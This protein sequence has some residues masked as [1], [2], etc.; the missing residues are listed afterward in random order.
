M[1]A[2]TSGPIVVNVL[3]SVDV[4]TTLPQFSLGGFA[5]SSPFLTREVSRF[6]PVVTFVGLGLLSS[7]STAD[8]DKQG[9]I[10][11]SFSVVVVIVFTY[12]C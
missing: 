6:F 5:V 9:S 7:S 8:V 11:S 1:V 10:I 2:I 3:V 4:T 12:A